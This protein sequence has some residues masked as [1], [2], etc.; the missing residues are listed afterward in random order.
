MKIGPR[1]ENAR[2]WLA[3]KLDLA[4]IPIADTQVA[5]TAARAIMAGTSL[6]IFDAIARGH[7]TPE[8]IAG[9]CRTHPRATRA[10]LDALVSIDYLS[11]RGGAYA[12]RRHVTK[13]LLA[14]APRSIRAK[15][16]FQRVEWEL[17][18][19]LEGFVRTGESLALHRMLGPE[20]QA[21]YQDGMRALASEIAPAIAGRLRLPR[22]PRRMVD[23]GGS[24]GFHAVALCRKH[25]TLEAE[26]LEL[27]GAV[28]AAAP[29]LAKENMGDRVRHR[30]GDALAGDLGRDLDLVL[31]AQLVHHFTAK[32][33]AALAKR[34]FRALRPGGVL[35]IADLERAPSPGAGGA[36]GGTMDLYFALTSRSG[37]WSV[38][39]M[40]QWQRDAGFRVRRAV[41]FP[42]LPGFVLQSGVKSLSRA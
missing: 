2:E 21:L 13:W 16:V 31:V 35:A 6:G 5:Y 34:A 15:L 32:E 28:T 27:P 1:P 24:H 22:S 17:L 12:N 38:P 19:G 39:E 4:P 8:A 29:L 37:T 14:D 41:R 10:L 33:N 25:P 40:Q 11:F 42:T 30:E 9:A 18:A 23:V 36:L 3:E 7:T 20:E 26:V